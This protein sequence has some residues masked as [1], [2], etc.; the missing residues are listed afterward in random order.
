MTSIGELVCFEEIVTIDTGLSVRTLCFDFFCGVALAR[1]EAKEYTEI[2]PEADRMRR[3]GCDD[4]GE[5]EIWR[6]SESKEIDATSFPSSAESSG[7]S[8]R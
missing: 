4:A 2:L 1:S 5:K 3:L 8:Q 6:A 7:T